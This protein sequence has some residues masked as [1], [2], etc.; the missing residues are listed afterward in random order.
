MSII[1]SIFYKFKLPP[2]TTNLRCSH[3]SVILYLTV[4]HLLSS[5]ELIAIVPQ[6]RVHKEVARGLKND[7]SQCAEKFRTASLSNEKI[8]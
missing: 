6:K 1:K 7:N 8:F 3:L 2:I 5:L 4:F